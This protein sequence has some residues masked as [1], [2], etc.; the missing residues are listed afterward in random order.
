[1]RVY[2]RAKI[3]GCKEVIHCADQGPTMAIYDNTDYL[4][5]DLI[6]YVRSRK[7]IEES[8]WL[9]PSKVDHWKKY[10][11]HVKFS[12]FFEGK[13]IF[14]EHEFVELV[15]DNFKDIE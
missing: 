3:F 5:D 4:A 12:D 9:E 6:E 14:K 15:F 2:E 8:N 1:M 7:Y 11:K 10:G 13:L